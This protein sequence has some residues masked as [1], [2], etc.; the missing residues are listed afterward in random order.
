M[1][2]DNLRWVWRA[3]GGCGGPEKGEEGLKWLLRAMG[4]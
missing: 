1:N 4:G 2:V 3:S